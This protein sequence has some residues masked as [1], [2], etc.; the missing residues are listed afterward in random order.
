MEI[1][2]GIFGGL[3]IL[4]VLSM[5]VISVIE[6]CWNNT[7]DLVMKLWPISMLFAVITFILLI[8]MQV[9]KNV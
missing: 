2:L 7:N 1:A 4:G 9:T 6:E 8:M 5:A 3:T